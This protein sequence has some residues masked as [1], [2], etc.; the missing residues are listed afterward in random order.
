MQPSVKIIITLLLTYSIL[1]SSSHTVTIDN[2]PYSTEVTVEKIQELAFGSLLVAS[3]G[4]IAVDRTGEVFVSGS[5]ISENESAVKPAI[6]E[7]KFTYATWEPDSLIGVKKTVTITV[8]TDQKIHSY[9]DS[10]VVNFD[11]E[12]INNSSQAT[13]TVGNIE[14]I[15]FTV[16]GILYVPYNT[17]NGYHTGKMKVTVM[18]YR[19]N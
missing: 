3:T 8:S 9:T 17:T 12:T 13:S 19:S 10:S 7:V 2:V 4:T 18:N 6:F 1:Y 15:T 14:T 11:F 16:G 5:V